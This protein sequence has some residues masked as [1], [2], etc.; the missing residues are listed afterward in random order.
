MAR[1]E[2]IQ[3]ESRADF[4]QLEGRESIQSG[5]RRFPA[6]TVAPFVWIPRTDSLLEQKLLR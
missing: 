6:A 4:A 5:R 3:K 2:V 1:A